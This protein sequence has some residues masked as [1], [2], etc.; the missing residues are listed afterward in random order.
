MFKFFILFILIC[1]ICAG[2]NKVILQEKNFEFNPNLKEAYIK[3]CQFKIQGAQQILLNESSNNGIK[4]LLDDYVDVIM[5]LNNGSQ[6][7]YENALI[8]ENE[9]LSIVGKLNNKSPYNK[10][11]KAE[12]KLHWALL[13]FR[14]GNEFLAA[15]DFIQ[16]HS[17]LEDNVKKYPEFLPQYKSLGAIHICLGTIPQNYTWLLKILGIEGGVNQGKEE[18]KKSMNDPLFRDE[19]Q[20]YDFLIQSYLLGFD[21]EM[22]NDL[23]KIIDTRPDYLSFYFLG[24]FI[25]SRNN[26][27]NQCDIVIQ[28]RPKG[29][30]YIYMP[31]FDFYIGDLL[32]QKGAYVQ[33]VERYLS[34][35]KEFKGLVFKKE[36]YQKIFFAFWL[37][38]NDTKAILFLNKIPING[39]MVVDADKFAQKFYESYNQ[40]KVLP[41]K[42]LIKARFSYDGGFYEKALLEIEEIKTV[43][44]FSVKY[45]A[46]YYYRKGQIYYKNKC[47]NKS[48]VA[49]LKSIDMSKNIASGFA[50]NSALQLGYIYQING[51]RALS[52]MYFEKAIYYSRFERKSVVDMRAKAG[53]EK[54]KN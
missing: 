36:A 20:F 5:L 38:N 33:A 4:I 8:K 32:L 3:I 11:V 28:K 22:Q 21:E 49:Y 13:K 29:S 6:K 51:D 54:F 46:E 37:I 43:E 9:R 25:L 27:N 31:I 48:I 45:K 12:I 18:L 30:E 53:I 15:R 42:S 14:F 26:N 35:I 40:D 34:Y 7:E 10:F 2:Q 16:A 47:I 44:S 24:A 39:N 17:L 41:N 50:S 52:I 19:A 23:K 1:T